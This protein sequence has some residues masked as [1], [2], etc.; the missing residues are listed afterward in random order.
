M[1]YL[2]KKLLKIAGS[3]ALAFCLSRHWMNLAVIAGWQLRKRVIQCFPSCFCQCEGRREITTALTI[4]PCNGC[5]KSSRV[6]QN[7][8]IDFASSAVSSCFFAGAAPFGCASLSWSRKVPYGIP[9]VDAA[10]WIDSSRPEQ[11]TCLASCISFYLSTS[12]YLH[13]TLLMVALL[14]GK[15]EYWVS[16]WGN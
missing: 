8:T 4:F 16:E 7:L 2:V 10:V 6:S 12:A 11:Y 5:P 9:F 3:F 13:F 1:I 14:R 15:R